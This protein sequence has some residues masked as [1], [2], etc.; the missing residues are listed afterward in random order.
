MPIHGARVPFVGRARELASLVA[1]LEATRAGGGRVVLLAGEP[2]IGKTRL[3]QEC[4]A[5]ASAQGMLVLVGRCAEGDG[6]PPY[7]PVVEALRSY[8]RLADVDALRAAVGASVA[9]VALLLPELFER[10]PELVPP[11]HAPDRFRLL[12]AVCEL[13]LAIERVGGAGLLLVLDDLHWAD[14][15]SLLLLE[16]LARRANEGPL[17]VLGAYRT[18]DLTRTHQTNRVLQA[19]ALLGVSLDLDLVLR[20]G[21]GDRATLMAAIEEA[22]AAGLHPRAL[23]PG[24]CRTSACQGKADHG[25]IAVRTKSARLTR[26]NE[27]WMY[28]DGTTA[29]DNFPSACQSS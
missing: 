2:G 11:P 25:A 5:A 3:L 23:S 15:P 19:G 4:A 18:T 28:C 17:L 21:L 14:T 10:L 22:T 12:D 1:A 20:M 9:F 8:L 29:S 24:C 26:R 13:L 27:R 6:V 7:L 16:Q